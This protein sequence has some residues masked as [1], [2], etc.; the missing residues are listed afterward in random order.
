MSQIYK[1]PSRH[2]EVISLDFGDFSLLASLGSSLLA[3]ISDACGIGSHALGR[4]RNFLEKRRLTTSSI[5][6]VG[7]TVT[8]RMPMPGLYN[9]HLM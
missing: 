2:A 6:S 3:V 5:W 1:I 9:A 4:V 8:Q 7:Y